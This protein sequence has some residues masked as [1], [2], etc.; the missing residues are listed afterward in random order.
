M[1]PSLIVIGASS[2][3]AFS[4]KST[5]SS[6]FENLL[7]ISSICA[8]LSLL[9]ASFKAGKGYKEDFNCNKSLPLA[10]PKEIRAI[11]LSKSY[12]SS[13]ITRTSLRII[14]LSIKL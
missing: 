10:L 11:N 5:K 7:A 3:I 1:P 12:T 8:L 14:K 2:E 6:K 9:K 13:N 4:I